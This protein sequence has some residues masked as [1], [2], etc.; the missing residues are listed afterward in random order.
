MLSFVFVTGA[1][2]SEAQATFGAIAYNSSNGQIGYSH[3]YGTYDEA[4]NGALNA[5]GGGCSLINWENGLC[6]A[7]ATGNGGWGESHGFG[8]SDDAVNAAVNACG[9]G[10]SWNVY[11]CD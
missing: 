7:F 1:A 4:V 9:A 2:F 6:N 11:I 5:C 8:N 3:G 10:C